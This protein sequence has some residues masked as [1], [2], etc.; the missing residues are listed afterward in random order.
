GGG[1][2]VGLDVGVVHSEQGLETLDR[3]VLHGVD[4]HLAFVVTLAGVALGVLVVQHAA[5][6]FQYGLG[7]VVFARDQPDGIALAS[8]F[9]AHELGNF[10]IDLG[11][12]ELGHGAPHTTFA[13]AGQATRCTL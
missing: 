12:V 4:V 13:G 10:R 8:L 7:R 5:R 6:G 3:Q 2:G 9:G 11:E 1:A